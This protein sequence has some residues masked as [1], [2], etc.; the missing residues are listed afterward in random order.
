MKTPQK[1]SITIIPMKL[2]KSYSK[3]IPKIV[4]KIKAKLKDHPLKIKKKLKRKSRKQ[5]LKF[6]NII[7]RLIN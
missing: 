5:L 7:F 3:L 4:Y 2:L 1:I 6:T